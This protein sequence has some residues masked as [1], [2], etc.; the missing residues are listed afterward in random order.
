MLRVLLVMENLVDE[1]GKKIAQLRDE[2]DHLRLTCTKLEILS[3]ERL[4]RLNEL[5]SRTV[6][7]ETRVDQLLIENCAFIRERDDGLIVAENLFARI[8]EMKKDISEIDELKD[9]LEMEKRVNCDLKNA[10]ADRVQIPARRDSS[11]TNEPLKRGQ[12]G[13]ASQTETSLVLNKYTQTIDKI[14]IR[15]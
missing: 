2:N 12:T 8:S 9:K 4:E 3:N 15:E 10:L 7:L 5:E 6:D 14:S 13:V 1:F 11:V